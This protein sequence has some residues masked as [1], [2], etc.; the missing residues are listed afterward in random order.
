MASQCKPIGDTVGDY[1][2]YEKSTTICENTMPVCT[3]SVK[4]YGKTKDDKPVIA[5]M[6]YCTFRDA[7]TGMIIASVAAAALGITA[8]VLGVK[9]AKKG[10]VV[11]A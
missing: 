8:I 2:L 6:N 10:N 4:F 5:V 7:K 11:V 1:T 3:P 9:L